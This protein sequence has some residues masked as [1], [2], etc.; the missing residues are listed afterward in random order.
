MVQLP[1]ARAVPLA[2]GP[3]AAHQFRRGRD[4]GERRFVDQDSTDGRCSAACRTPSDS[5]MPPAPTAKAP[6]QFL[7]HR[8]TRCAELFG[9]VLKVRP[10]LQ[11]G[12]LATQIQRRKAGPVAVR[13]VEDLGANLCVERPE[14]ASSRLRLCSRTPYSV[15]ST[16]RTLRKSLS[17][18]GSPRLPAAGPQLTALS[19]IHPF[20]SHAVSMPIAS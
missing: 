9:T 6:R 2:S 20:A 10:R 17:V 3:S 11:F 4:A 1:S 5:R 7:P 18:G 19:F 15:P 16:S 14:M 12:M 13:R 8:P